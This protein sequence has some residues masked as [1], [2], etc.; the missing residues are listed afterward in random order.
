MLGWALAIM[1]QNTI[2][3]LVYLR[4]VVRREKHESTWNLTTRGH[5]EEKLKK[6]LLWL[7]TLAQ[8]KYLLKIVL[9]PEKCRHFS[10][11]HQN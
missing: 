8:Y 10:V 9:N 1:Q 2:F 3:E 5:W 6:T 11:S 7:S 4:T